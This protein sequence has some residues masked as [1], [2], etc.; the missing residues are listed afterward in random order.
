MRMKDYHRALKP[1]V[2]IGGSDRLGIGGYCRKRGFTE[3]VSQVCG[4]TE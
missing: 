3:G 1:Q 4:Q 2:V